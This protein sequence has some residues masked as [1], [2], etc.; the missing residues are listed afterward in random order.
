MAVS[1]WIVFAMNYVP[2]RIYISWLHWL[3]Y[4]VPTVPDSIQIAC[5]AVAETNITNSGMAWRNYLSLIPR[6]PFFALQ[7]CA[8]GVPKESV[9]WLELQGW[10]QGWGWC[11]N[12]PKPITKLNSLHGVVQSAHFHRMSKFGLSMQTNAASTQ[13]KRSQT[14]FSLHVCSIVQQRDV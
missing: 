12:L 7:E 4:I 1:L 6:V 5:K 11:S 3:L 10:C 9:C 13:A 2:S 14:R 8:A